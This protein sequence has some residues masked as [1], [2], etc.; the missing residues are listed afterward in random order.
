MTIL[1]CIYIITN[2]DDFKHSLMKFFLI[3]SPF[4]IEV[5]VLLK[6]NSL[7]FFSK[8]LFTNRCVN[9]TYLFLQIGKDNGEKEVFLMLDHGES[10][11]KKEDQDQKGLNQLFEIINA[12]GDSNEVNEILKSGRSENLMCSNELFTKD[13]K[14]IVDDTVKLSER[15]EDSVL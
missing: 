10:N 8:A 13:L 3:S 15:D 4:S 7:S 14:A 9:S 1:C 12:K 5:G 6:R 11:Q 2:L